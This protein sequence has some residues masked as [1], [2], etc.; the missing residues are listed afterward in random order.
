MRSIKPAPL[1]PGDIIGIVAPASAP[2]TPEAMEAGIAYLER[3]GYR[4]ELG[5]SVL[6]PRGY[7]SG[8]DE[9]RLDELNAFLRRDDVKML[10][11]VR[12]GY[13]I[14]R[15]LPHLDYA[16]LLT[17]PKLIVGYSDVTALHLA[18]Y[19]KTGLPGLSGPLVVEWGDADT[20]TERSFWSLAHGDVPQPLLGPADEPLESVRPGIAEGVLLGGNLAVLVRMVGT[21]YLP[22][23]NGAILFLEDVGELPYRIDGMLAHLR[24]AGLLDQLGGLVLGGFTE[25]EPE[26]DRPT[27]ALDEVFD[28]YLREAPFPVARGLVY[29]HFPIKSTIPIG[30]KARL[31]VTKDAAALS[32]LEPVVERANR[33]A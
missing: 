5:R 13:G 20:G 33:A 27:L 11:S 3:R 8:T 29:G 32:I 6:A 12:G 21:P 17:H 23:L 14:L 24:L 2:R 22:S 30:V 19:K 1:E 26:D 10:V 18:I 28:D 9:E 7:L 15:L 25:W 31:E 16:A 4:V